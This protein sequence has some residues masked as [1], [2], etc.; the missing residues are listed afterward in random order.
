MKSSSVYNSRWNRE[1]QSYLRTHPLCEWCS[2]QGQVIPATVVD[3]IQPHRFKEA[4]RS[5]DKAAIAKAQKLFWDTSNWQRR[6]K[7]HYDSTRQRSEKSG[8]LQGCDEGD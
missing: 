7:L 4:L 3:H 2:Q 8:R 1:R 6:C 5:G